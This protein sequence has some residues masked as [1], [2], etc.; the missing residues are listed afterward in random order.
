MSFTWKNKDDQKLFRTG[1][2][3]GGQGANYH[4]MG[5]GKPDDKQNISMYVDEVDETIWKEVLN[6]ENKPLVIA[7]VDYIHPLFKE[8]SNYKFI[9]PEGLTG[10]FE[11]TDTAT[12]HSRS[13]EL[14]KPHFEQSKKKALEHYGNKSA[15]A[16]TTA[17]F[18]EV[19]PAAYYGRVDTLFVKKNAELW[20]TFDE[21]ESVLH[22]HPTRQDNDESLIDKTVMKTIM[23][24]GMV[25]ELDGDE[26][27]VGETPF[28]ALMRY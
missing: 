22:I 21:Q 19:I 28:A 2:S 27:P 3:G 26:M 4:G 1:S 23:N 6:R 14:V 8:V 24:G 7:A 10:N 25:Y 12:L 11:T 18:D 9:W 5:A 13:W 17:N 15:T 20:G 16:L